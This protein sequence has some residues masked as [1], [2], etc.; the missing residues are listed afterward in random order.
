MPLG[1]NG[2]DAA[3]TNN[4]YRMAVGRLEIPSASSIGIFMEKFSKRY[5]EQNKDSFF[6]NAG[7]SYK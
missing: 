7:K 6:F 4:T 1:K 2:V 5:R 3:W